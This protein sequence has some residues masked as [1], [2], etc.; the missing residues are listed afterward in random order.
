MDGKG[1]QGGFPARGLTRAQRREALAVLWGRSEGEI[2][3]RDRAWCGRVGAV[4]TARAKGR[5]PTVDAG[6]AALPVLMAAKCKGC[7]RTFN[8]LSGT[9]LSG[10]HHMIRGSLAK[11]ETV[12]ASA[13]R[14]GGVSTSFRWRH[15]SKRFGGAQGIVE[16]D[17]NVLESRKGARGLRTQ[18]TAAGR[19]SHGGGPERDDGQR[20]A[21]QAMRRRS[22]LLSPGGRE[23]RPAGLRRWRELPT[24]R[25]RARGEPRSAQPLDGGTGSGRSACADGEQPPQPVEASCVPAAASPPAI[26]T[27]LSCHLVGLPPAPMTGPVS[28]T[29][30]AYNSRIEPKVNLIPAVP[31][32]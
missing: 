10:L 20:C 8:A 11:G 31:G 27:T 24:L 1:F 4:R 12:R 21:A 29:R 17:E 25:R 26:W 13:A 32:G 28:I 7:G 5:F 23:G 6:S 2:E 9:P 15:R 19:H 14:C 22:R 18:G 3:G 30:C 16:A